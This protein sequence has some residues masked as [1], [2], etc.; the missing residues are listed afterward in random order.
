MNS[1]RVDALETHYAQVSAPTEYDVQVQVAEA[2]IDVGKGRLEDYQLVDPDL[3]RSRRSNLLY[4]A[5]WARVQRRLFGRDS[6]YMP[7]TARITSYLPVEP[8]PTRLVL[9]V[10]HA[11]TVPLDSYRSRSEAFWAWLDFA[12]IGGHQGELL[13]PAFAHDHDAHVPNLEHINDWTTDWAEY[14]RFTFAQREQLPYLTLY[15]EETVQVWRP[16]AETRQLPVARPRTSRPDTPRSP[17]TGHR[18]LPGTSRRPQP[19]PHPRS[20]PLPLLQRVLAAELPAPTSAR[21]R[22]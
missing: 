21:R 9:E 16:L 22:T 4:Q 6:M 5:S 11:I 1:P 8:L 2:L 19:A 7:V 12:I 3:V 15:A 14:Q 20:T 17:R 13:R 18:E 10:Q